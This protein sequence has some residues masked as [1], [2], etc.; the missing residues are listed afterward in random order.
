MRL[1]RV[2]L[3]VVA[4]VAAAVPVIALG[5]AP[6][7]AQTGNP[8]CT[9]NTVCFSYPAQF[10]G[11]QSAYTSYPELTSVPNLSGEVFNGGGPNGKGLPV[12]G[13]IGEVVNHALSNTG[14]IVVLCSGTNYTGDCRLLLPDSGFPVNDPFLKTVHSFYWAT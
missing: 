4:A 11:K 10:N 9:L 13:N 6:A 1:K 8:T 14:L 7:Q 5:A 3:C 2:L 12:V